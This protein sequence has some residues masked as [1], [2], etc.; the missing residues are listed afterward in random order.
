VLADTLLPGKSTRLSYMTTIGSAALD[1][2]GVNRAYGLAL[3]P[4]GDTVKAP[5][6]AVAVVVRPGIF[7]DHGIVIGKIFFEENENGSQ[8]F[9]EAGIA[10]VELW[11]EDGTHIITGNDGKF[12]LPDV[13]PGQHVIRVDQRTLPAGSTLLPDGTESA[14]SG[15]T[16]FIRLV[17]GGVA[18]ADFHVRPPRQ[19]S[20]ELSVAPFTPSGR[21]RASFVVR[22]ATKHL[23]STIV[24]IDTL[25][26]GLLYDMHSLTLNGSSI[27]GTRGLSRSLRLELPVRPL[28]SLDT[29]SVA[30]V[31]DSSYTKRVGVMRPTLV[32]SYP[33]RR[34]AVFRTVETFSVPA[35]GSFGSLTPQRAKEA[36]VTATA[37]QR[38][39][40]SD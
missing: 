31:S 16:R 9:S 17:E 19:A 1:G 28:E 24:L 10:G 8:E 18:R 22:C 2:D 7:T 20:L 4:T 38:K 39:K 11:M 32:L 15:A 23:P 30:L 34:D 25:P 27:A 36:A 14:G 37:E 29:V 6:S 35:N 12:S 40:G 26:K 33:Q 21:L 3:G 5:V 13:K